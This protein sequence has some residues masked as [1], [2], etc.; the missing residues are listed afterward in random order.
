MKDIILPNGIILKPIPIAPNDDYKAGSDGQ[1]YSNFK[2]KGFGKK[3]YVDWYPLKSY[4][5]NRGWYRHV[6]LSHENKRITKA[7]H[8][9]VCMA[10][11]GMP[12]SQSSEVRH[13]DGDNQNS[14][15][16]NLA[17]GTRAENWADRKAHGKSP[18][19]DKNPNSKLTN[20]ERSAL[21]W[22]INKGLCSQHHAAR[23]FG[24]SQTSMKAIA[25]S[26]IDWGYGYG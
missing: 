18:E 19:G 20:F 10:F 25:H 2:Y 21:R 22:A 7:V 1:I 9:L 13:L 8:R 17:W 23:I 11:H 24:M 3:L 14:K 12:P 4:P 15:P 16:D 5:D 6:T 26:K